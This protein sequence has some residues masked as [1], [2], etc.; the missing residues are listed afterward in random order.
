MLI[1]KANDETQ[2]LIR[3]AGRD[4]RGQMVDVPGITSF[5][6][7]VLLSQEDEMAL[8]QRLGL[9]AGYITREQWRD[10]ASLLRFGKDAEFNERFGGVEA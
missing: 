4:E 3:T 6:D 9:P 7:L 8:E 1:E 10:Q 5:D 2:Q